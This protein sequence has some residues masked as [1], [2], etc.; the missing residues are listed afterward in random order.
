MRPVRRAA[1]ESALLVAIA[2]VGAAGISRSTNTPEARL[3]GPIIQTPPIYD[4]Q[5]KSLWVR[6]CVASG[7]EVAFCRCA[8]EEY[9]KKLRPD[10]FETASVIAL[11][12]GVEAELPQHVREVV[13]DVERKCG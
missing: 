6:G 4:P 12:Q 7:N 5:F 8:I 2:V 3:E 1:F 13:E 10:E 11:G 9:T